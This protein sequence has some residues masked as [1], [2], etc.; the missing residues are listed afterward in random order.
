MELAAE[1]GWRLPLRAGSRGEP[2]DPVI[3]PRPLVLA[4]AGEPCLRIGAVG[5]V[6]EEHRLRAPRRIDERLNVAARA[7]DERAIAAEEARRAIARLPRRDV[8][9]RRADGVHVGAHF[10][11]VDRRP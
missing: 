1:A 11:E 2:R 7:L 4:G 9:A 3:P 10:A 8:I 6:R 5:V